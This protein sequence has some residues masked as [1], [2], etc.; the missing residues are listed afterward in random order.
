MCPSSLREWNGMAEASIF[1][2]HAT[3][4]PLLWYKIGGE[5]RQGDGRAGLGRFAGPD[6]RGWGGG[7]HGRSESCRV[8]LKGYNKLR[9]RICISIV[10]GRILSTCCGSTELPTGTIGAVLHQLPTT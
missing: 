5:L 9:S 10:D 6:V 8:V 7:R 1:Q 4:P 2:R 3:P